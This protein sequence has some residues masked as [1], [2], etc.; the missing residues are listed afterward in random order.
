MLRAITATDAGQ[1][2]GAWR[3]DMSPDVVPKQGDRKANPARRNKP[4]RPSAET[5][6]RS[7]AAGRSLAA[8]LAPEWEKRL[9]MNPSRG[10]PYKYAGPPTG[11]VACIRRMIGKGGA[12]NGRGRG[13]DAGTRRQ[14][15]RRASPRAAGPPKPRRVAIH[16]A[17]SAAHKRQLE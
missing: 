6:A 17:P 13:Q 12:R 9:G 15:P 14:V 4:K 2:M 1:S 11:G 3:A 5:D 7:E 8:A 10:R 16:E